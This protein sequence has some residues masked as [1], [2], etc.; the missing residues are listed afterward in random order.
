MKRQLRLVSKKLNPNQ[1]GVTLGI[2]SAGLHAIWALIVLIGAEQIIFN[3]IFPLHFIDRGYTVIS[4]N[5]ITAIIMVILAF[6]CGYA[7]GWIFAWLWN[8]VCKKVR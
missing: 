1:V 4:F 8:W 6:L 7:S 2:F 5:I 3:W